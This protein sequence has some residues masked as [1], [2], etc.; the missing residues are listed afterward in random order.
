MKGN[1]IIAFF[2][3]VFSVAVIA[4]AMCQLFGVWEK[5]IYI[6]EPLLGIIL[7]LQAVQSWRTNRRLALFQLATAGFILCAA[8]VILLF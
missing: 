1:K 6:Q 7:I 2:T 4:L 5:A 3:I 8:A